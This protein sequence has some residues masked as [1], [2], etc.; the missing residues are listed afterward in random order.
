MGNFGEIKNSTLGPGAKM[1]HFSY[2]GD[3]E[4]GPGANIGAGT[5]TCNYDG[6]KKHRT[7]IEEG[8]FIGSD[9]MLVAP[10]RVG[11]G[12]TTGA[13]AVVTRDVPDGKVVYGVP[14]RV[15]DKKK[16]D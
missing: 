8:A 16:A 4:V 2:L 9:T 5:I 7:V 3:A 10:V 13:G 12:A 15:R 11:K 1:G 6:V 14:A